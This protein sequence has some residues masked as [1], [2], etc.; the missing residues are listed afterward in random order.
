MAESLLIDKSLSKEAK[1]QALL[2]QIEALVT[3]ETDL[4]ANLANLMAALKYSLD[5]YWVGAYLVKE[6]ELVL[7]PFQG[8]VACTR[9][10]F[11]KGVC[12]ASYTRKK[13]IL[14]PDVDAFPGHIACSSASRSEIVVPVLKD[15]EVKMVL[16]VDSDKLD[17]FDETDKIYLEQLADL[18]AGW[19]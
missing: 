8:P 6:G 13:T 10:P 15:G 5:F 3:G 12:G 4:T 16:D 14:V 1:Y 19:F 17:N 9:I 2:P 18:M 7:G 11:H